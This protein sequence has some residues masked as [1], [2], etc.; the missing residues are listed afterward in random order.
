MK[1]TSE[2]SPYWHR[3]LKHFENRGYVHNGLTIPFLIGALE[4]IEP[5]SQ[6]W[7]IEAIVGSFKKIGCTILKCGNLNEFV[8]GTLDSETLNYNKEYHR[9][10]ENIFITDHSLYQINSCAEIITLF[11]ELYQS[12]LK[13]KEFSKVLGHW[14]YF[15]EID[16]KQI[17]EII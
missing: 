9:P 6:L 10:C 11:K 14:A 7:S 15:T 8:I 1:M 3:L 2:T 5:N 13:E 17:R 12:R 16:L 4:I